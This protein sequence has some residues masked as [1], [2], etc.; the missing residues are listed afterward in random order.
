LP[1]LTLA[2]TDSIKYASGGSTVVEHLPYHPKVE[3]SSPAEIAGT[4]REK[5]EKMTPPL[6]Y[7][8][9]CID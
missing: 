3:G 6:N 7:I 8:D 1:P 9:F 5:I 2:Q 4:E